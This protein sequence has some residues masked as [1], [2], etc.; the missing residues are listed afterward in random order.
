M[1]GDDDGVDV[2]A[3]SRLKPVHGIAFP[4]EVR[5]ICRS[6]L[7]GEAVPGMPHRKQVRSYS[8]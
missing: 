2:P 7:V 1:S 8:L 4:C 5:D 6:E 3:S